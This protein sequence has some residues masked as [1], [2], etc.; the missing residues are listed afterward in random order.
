MKVL[1][2]ILLH[3]SVIISISGLIL[4]LDITTQLG[5][6]TPILYIILVLYSYFIKQLNS[7]FVLAI[8]AGGL[9]VVGAILSPEADGI[10]TNNGYANRGLSFFA[11]A[12]L[13][14]GIYLV[15]KLQGELIH[16]SEIEAS[17]RRL[18]SSQA[19]A[20]IGSWDW[21]LKTN[22]IS[23]SEE[24][25]NIYGLEKEDTAALGG[26]DKFIHPDDLARV[27]KITKVHYANKEPFNIEYRIVDTNNEEKYVVENVDVIKSGSGRII[28]MY[29]VVHDVTE[30]KKTSIELQ[31]KI[32]SLSEFENRT[33]KILDALIR[34]TQGNYSNQIDITSR[35]D[36]LDAISLGIN[37]LA[38]ELQIS[39]NVLKDRN[40]E[41]LHQQ[42]ELQSTNE[43]LEEQSRRLK[44]QQEE[45]EVSNEEM[46][47]QR[48]IILNTNQQLIDKANELKQSNKYKSDFLANMSHELRSPLNSILLLAN[49]L[50]EN[51]NNNLSDDQIQSA[52]IIYEG[53]KDLLS[54]IN[55]ILD[56]SKIEAGKLEIN[57]EKVELSNVIHELH[58]K[59]QVQLTEKNLTFEA[60]I[61]DELETNAIRTDE[62]R[63]K[64]V[65]G[66]LLSN[67]IKFTS[68]GSVTIAVLPHNNDEFKIEVTD[69][70][71]GIPTAKQ[72]LI[73]DAFTQA[74]GSTTRKFGG[75]GL[76][77]TITNYL[78]KMLNG[79]ISLKSKEREGTTFSVT[80]P[81]KASKKNIGQP[82]Y[83]QESV[84][85]PA[86]KAE[87]NKVLIVED[88]VNFAKILQNKAKEIG[89]DPVLVY[90]GQSALDKLSDDKIAAV[91]LD[92]GLPD[93]S[94]VEIIKQ[95]RES[96]N[97]YH[98]P[99]HVISAYD[100]SE[101]ED[102]SAVKYLTKPVNN[103]ELHKTF[104]E[105]K[106]LKDE[107]PIKNLLIVEDHIPT[108]SA[109]RM[110]LKYDDLKI[111]ETSTKKEAIEIIESAEVDC[112][113]LDMNLPDG[114]GK[115]VIDECY[116]AKNKPLPW[117]IVY[118]SNQLSEEEVIEIKGW[119]KSIVV[120]GEYSNKRLIDEA[121]LFLDYHR[122]KTGPTEAISKELIETQLKKHRK[123]NNKNV[124]LVDD[125]M[126]NIFALTKV[127][128][129][130]GLNITK[131]TNGIKALEALNEKRFDMVLM[132]IM[133]PEM[134]GY[135]A[136]EKIR[137]QEQYKELPIIALTAKAMKGDKEKCL[138][139]GANDYLP[140]PVNVENLLN[141]MSI[142]IN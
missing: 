6:A 55:D 134:D 33:N 87:S 35:G 121:V 2:S 88:D 7:S 108:R 44:E 54:L 40:V 132:D 56:L 16:S 11:I 86:L 14:Y 38:E 29:G 27:S 100:K 5:I 110:L 25:Y 81:Y 106:S 78:V 69:T 67:A 52:K 140:K 107:T 126:R 64:Q 31:D 47:E 102:V 73:F 36:E 62:L 80:F 15:K 68:K 118:T 45:L 18:K 119:A 34:I 89:F 3:I 137:G 90:D 23:W 101:I 41:L 122:K 24:L 112:I 49:D 60:K 136:I 20:H 79:S 105:I 10:G 139:V 141:L 91:I 138:T 72:Q 77:L 142:W 128:S 50:A 42:E 94:G 21:D 123:L 103:A 116:I 22:I 26:G 83:T 48:Q 111:T 53:G 96:P 127:L 124:L 51:A 65:I 133:M 92:I 9:I 37:T 71:I 30:L 113:I 104:L 28:G 76:G 85:Q 120:K 8:F 59:Y 99:I 70:G 39:I 66:N 61:A 46:E 130:R 4:F 114:N 74:D 98:I 63:I 82:V 32:G 43:E 125:D 57:I 75:T 13:S 19:L 17:N 117:I 1:D 115:E 97:W 58:N 135:E 12:I 109:L 95:M 129:D 93:M 84:L 131:A